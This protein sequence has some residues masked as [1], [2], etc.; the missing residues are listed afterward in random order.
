MINAATNSD[1]LR[2]ATRISL[3]GKKK[4]ER[5]EWRRKRVSFLVD[6]ACDKLEQERYAQQTDEEVFDGCEKEAK[7]QFISRFKTERYGSALL[8]FLLFQIIWYLIKK[9]ILDE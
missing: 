6:F 4:Y 1:K 2:A 7:E 8:T 3:A 9:L 5:I